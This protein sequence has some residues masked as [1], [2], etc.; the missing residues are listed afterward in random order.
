[1]NP[2]DYR[3]RRSTWWTLATIFVIAVA[4]NYVWELAQAPLYTGMGDFSR[5][6]WHCFVPSLGDGL[7]VL[8]IF[9]LGWVV[10]QRGDWFM[11]PG[12]RGYVLMLIAGLVIAISIELM[13]VYIL[14]RWEYTTQMPLVPGLGVGVTPIAQML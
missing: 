4:F 1:M 7:L 14:R 5:M 11:R 2:S 10:L 8:L 6:L 3:R 13:A 12:V 9:A